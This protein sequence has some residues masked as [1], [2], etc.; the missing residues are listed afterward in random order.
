MGSTAGSGSGDFH[1]YRNMRRREEDRLMRMDKDWEEKVA[2][3]KHRAAMAANQR[4]SEERT[5][6]RAAKRRRKKEARDRARAAKTARPS[7]PTTGGASGGAGGAAKGSTGAGAG[8]GGGEGGASG[9]APEEVL[10]AEALAAIEA[11]ELAAAKG[12][13]LPATKYKGDGT[14]AEQVGKSDRGKDVDKVGSSGDA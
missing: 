8:A 6:K 7:S 11:A 1:A 5:A 2:E 4:E 3:D 14:F 13:G 12:E 9:A 10:S